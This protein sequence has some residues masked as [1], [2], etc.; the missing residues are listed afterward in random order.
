MLKLFLTF[1]AEVY[2]GKLLDLTA[3]LKRPNQPSVQHLFFGAYHDFSRHTTQK[4]GAGQLSPSLTSSIY[5]LVHIMISQD[6]P[7][8]K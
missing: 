4:I 8:K 7:P 5:F 1:L 3:C 2:F 6:I